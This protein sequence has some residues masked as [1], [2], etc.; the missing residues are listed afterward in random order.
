MHSQQA[1]S[2]F[3]AALDL[4]EENRVD[5]AT[6]LLRT[7]HEQS[8]R[9]ARVN[10]SLGITAHR[11][12]DDAACLK[13]LKWAAAVAKKKA[14]VFEELARA[15]MRAGETK[16]AIDAARKA[17]ALAPKNPDMHAVL[18]DVYQGVDRALLA[19]RSYQRALELSPDH[20]AALTGLA[21][22]RITAGEPKEAEA[23]LRRATQSPTGDGSI[24][25]I[26]LSQL[27]KREKHADDL[28]AVERELATDGH[29]NAREIGRLH[30]AAAVMADQEDE[31]SR[32]FEHYEKG[33]Q[34]FYPPYRVETYAAH[35]DNAR[36]LFTKEFFLERRD[37]AF[38]TRKPV[39]VV[40]MPR[41]GTTLAEQIISRH[42]QAAGAGELGF[43]NQQ[44]LALGFR[45]ATPAEFTKNVLSLTTRDLTRI[46]RK[47]LAQL[48]QL[49]PKAERVVDK[50]PHN[51]E[52][53]WLLALL[54]PNA[55]FIHCTREPADTC[56]SIFTTPLKPSHRYNRSQRTLG[57]YYRDYRKL[58]THWHETLPVTVHDHSY[59]A[60]IADQEAQS[61][62]LIAHT[63]LEWED[64]CLEFYKGEEA[65]KTFSREQVRQP[66]YASS[67]ARWQ[68]YEAHIGPLL[69]ALGDLAPKPR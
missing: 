15:H 44:N 54:F 3:Q 5:D 11:A 40:G 32:A 69:A 2:M 20:V 19:E 16:E 53:L 68:R 25:Y 38:E 57:L 22:L 55:T 43:F 60:V 48:D 30:F 23:L 67:V 24:A 46:G 18:G 37:A 63:G 47:Y 17:I 31:V 21:D 10:F 8:P 34:G 45:M 52:S 51:F 12:G 29:R 1:E 4:L 65:V 41:S 39:F 62:A 6:P 14:I 13:H 36:A 50:M 61:R 49:A 56:V 66:I 42:S 59:E 33:H 64:A 27:R 7:L 28:P 35:V 9:D 26:P 58:M